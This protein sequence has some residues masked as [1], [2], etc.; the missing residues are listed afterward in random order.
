MGHRADL[1]SQLKKAPNRLYYM[2]DQEIMSQFISD[3]IQGS[4]E[5]NCPVKLKNSLTCVPRWNKVLAKLKAEVRKLFKQARNSS[6]VGDWERFRETQLA[7]TVGEDSVR[8]LK[9]PRGMETAQ[10]S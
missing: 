3:T 2:E 8:A 10:D 6:E 5:I 7:E 4:F 9:S 1:E